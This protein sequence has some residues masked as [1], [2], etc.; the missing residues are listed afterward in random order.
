MDNESNPYQ[1][2]GVEPNAD[3]VTIKR[4][5]R[6][7]SFQLHPD[8]NAIASERYKSI[9]KAYETLSDLDKRQ[10]FDLRQRKSM[11]NSSQMTNKNYNISEDNNS[12]V[13]VIVQESDNNQEQ[14]QYSNYKMNNQ[15]SDIQKTVEITLTDC[16]QG[17]SVPIRILRKVNDREEEV[18]LYVDIP[19][20]TDDGEVIILRGEGNILGQEQSNVRVRVY[21]EKDE[22]YERQGMNLIYNMELS[23]K[24]A[25]CGFTREIDHLDGKTYKIMSDKGKVIQ[26][27][28]K[29]CIRHKGFIRDRAMVTGSLYI[30]F[31]VKLP[32]ELK[33]EV[34]DKLTSLL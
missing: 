30:M 15:L 9:V 16:Y 27:G 7:L 17:A 31:D 1:I 29:R 18:S 28:S 5:F 25:L 19:R 23:L 24:E 2:L 32:T 22:K 13:S 14:R 10:M 20:G 12:C 26:P 8:K 11:L 34:I 3:D 21:V 6:R 33:P 4:A